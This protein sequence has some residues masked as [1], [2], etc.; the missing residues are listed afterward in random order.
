MKKEIIKYE[1]PFDPFIFDDVKNLVSELY[2]SFR[3]ES[4]RGILMIS[5][6]EIEAFLELLIEANIPESYSTSQKKSLF[7]Y[8]GK[9]ST[10]SDKLEMAYI[11]RLIGKP[12]FDSIKELKKLRNDAAHKKEVMTLTELEKKF[13][14]VSKQGI[15]FNSIFDEHSDYQINSNLLIYKKKLAE[16]GFPK[17]FIELKIRDKETT[18]G[19]Q[20]ERQTW[21]FVFCIVGICGMIKRYTIQNEKLFS[22]INHISNI[23]D[24]KEY[25]DKI[26]S[27]IFQTESGL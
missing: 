20:Q 22:R 19:I 8:P 9:L 11:F 5:C 2:N 16:Q 27:E 15:D 3:I 4:A 1:I 26:S 14:N 10:F 17:G 23:I 21:K 25:L 6:T 24:S 18:E 12:L 7:N 13:D